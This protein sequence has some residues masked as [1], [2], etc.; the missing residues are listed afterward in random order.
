VSAQEKLQRA[1][2]WR[3]FR[4][5]CYG[6]YMGF[7]LSR[8]GFTDYEE[9]HKMFTFTDLNLFL[10]FCG[11]V[12][13][14]AAAYWSVQTFRGLPGKPYHGGS[15]IGG[16]TFGAGWAITGACPSVALI[17]IGGGQFAAFA[18]FAGVLIGTFLYP[19][20]HRRFFGWDMGTCGL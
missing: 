2:R 14:S 9:V 3:Q 12:C 8:V 10:T 19:K 16:V 11:G 18:T 17:M 1:E 6:L 7:I 5:A 13:L 4:Y 15:I 20:I